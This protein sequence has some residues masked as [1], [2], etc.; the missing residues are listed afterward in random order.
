MRQRLGWT[1][2]LWSALMLRLWGLDQHNIWWDEGLT[3]WA[4]RLPIQGILDWT[5]HDVHPPLYFLITHGWWQLLGD[6]AWGLRFLPALA[7]VLAVVLA[8]GLARM[9]GGPRAGLLAGLF[10]ALSPFAV[11][12]SQELRMYIWSALWAAAA[13]WA[14]VRIW[15]TDADAGHGVTGEK[16]D[17]LAVWIAYVLSAAAGLWTLYLSAATLVVA[18]LAFLW[19]W[20]QRGR[21]KGLLIRWTMAQVAVIGLFAPWLAYALPRMMSWSSAEPYQ[22]GFFLRLYA[23]VLATGAAADL[24][25]WTWPTVAV[26]ITLALA[27]FALTFRRKDV[28]RSTGLVMLLLG[29]VL[30]AALVYALTVPGRAF[31][32]PRLAPRYFLPLAA[33]F[34]ILLGWGLSVL[35]RR[36]FL[37]LAGAGIVAGVSLTG[38][39]ALYTGRG[40]T[41]QY[42]SLAAT[43]EAHRRPADAV[44]LYT[45]ADWP[46]FAAHYPGQWD[47][48]PGGMTISPESVEGLL[49]PIWEKAEGVWLVVIPNAQQTDPAQLVPAWLAARAA[50]TATW[51]YGETSLALFARTAERAAA[52]Y[53]LAPGFR[54]PRGSALPVAGGELLAAS[55]PLDRYLVGDILHL[56]LTW[57]RPPQEPARLLLAGPTTREVPLAA[58]PAVSTGPTR[59]QVD[60]PL[61]A[62][63]PA[64]RYSLALAAA[65]HTLELARFTLVARRP[66]LTEAAAEIMQPLDLRLGDSIRLVGYNLPRTTARPG[67]TVALT[68]YWEALAPIPA[69]YKVFTH[70]VGT[71]WN[72]A[73]GN[74]LWGQQDN[75]PLADRLPTTLWAPGVRVADPYRIRLDPAAPPGVYTL[76]VGMYG[77][78][79]GVRPP[80]FDGSGRPLGDSVTLAEI[81]VR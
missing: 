34:Y 26:L 76:E 16:K 39:A 45:D 12:W 80:V 59:Q 41:D 35:A 8:A 37:G 38:L 2:I 13:L 72:A 64:G 63:L 49:S 4:A 56:A 81:T 68:L 79:D 9:L 14:A 61:L 54:P 60:W 11:T 36:R 67:E 40:Q 77:L 78:V 15:Q 44:V 20:W 17:R 58:P 62:D 55:L 21:G 42:L 50:G 25:A 6:G 31:Y 75:E 18:N 57:A 27:V 30:P 19:T 74:F 33:C 51:S 43:L 29:L 53:D 22:P 65:G 70:L 24:E 48:V 5:A 3:A 7:G 32:V 47:R 1:L 46:L 23:T 69:R 66:L 52:A 71:T 73:Q 28:V 10:L